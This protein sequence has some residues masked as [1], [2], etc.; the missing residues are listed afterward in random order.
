MDEKYLWPLVGVALGWLLSVV[1]TAVKDRADQ[2][3]K[4]GRLVSKL[5][6]IHDQIDT[7]IVVTEKIKD[8]V[9]GWENY[10]HMR[11]GIN[12]RHFLEP[13][14]HV[15]SLREAVDEL[16]ETLPVEAVSLHG[17][18]DMLLKN[19]KASLKAVSKNHDLYVRGIS[20]YEAG[21]QLM[22]RDLS[23]RIHRLALRHGLGTYVSVLLS[24]RRKARN[25]QRTSEFGDKFTE[26]SFSELNR[27]AASVETP[28]PSLKGS[29]NGGPPGPVCGAV[30][31]PQPVPSV[32]PS[33]PP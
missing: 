13:A 30:H 14:S 26:D 10:E 28:N 15:D 33:M 5:L 18:I 20:V 21:M 27:L 7:L 29:T 1:S 11:K 8:H 32:S 3:R 16:S 19:K 9:Y 31:S 2:R 17:F 6:V 22:Q 25:R 24:E 23:K 12:E 4:L